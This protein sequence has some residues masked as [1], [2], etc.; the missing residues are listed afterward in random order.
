MKLEKHIL[1]IVVLLTSAIVTCAGTVGDKIHHYGLTFTSHTVN[2]DERTGMDLIP[3]KGLHFTSGFS[4]EFDLKLKEEDSTYGY[5]FRIISN[6]TTALDLVANLN[7]NKLNFIFVG[8]RGSTVANTEFRGIDLINGNRWIKVKVQLNQNE[9]C[10]TLD[11]VSRVIPYSFK[12]FKNIKIYFG[13]NKHLHFY[14]TDVPP[15]TIRNI[16]LKDDEERIVRKWTLAKHSENRVYDETNAHK[17]VVTHG[18]WEIE[19]YTRWK[20]KAS[21]SVDAKKTQIASDVLNGRV[22]V[23]TGNILYIYYIQTRELQRIEC[24]NKVPFVSG[25]SQMIYDSQKDRLISYSIVYPDFE[26]FDFTTREWSSDRID[27]G[28]APIQH[29]N[30]FIDPETNQ[31]IVFGGYGNHIYHSEVATHSLDG[32]SWQIDTLS[33]DIIPRYLSAVGFLGDGKFLVTGGYGSI[34]GKQ[35]E[36]PQNLYDLCE[37]DYINRTGRKLVDLPV[38]KEPRVLGNSMVIDKESNKIYTLV[39]NNEKFN[40]VIRLLSIDLNSKKQEILGDSIPFQFI[41]TESF[42]DLFLFEKTSDLYAVV[43]Q[44]SLSGT[45]RLELYSLA[46]PS[47][48]AADV[49]QTIDSKFSC[50]T[51]WEIIGGLIIV[52]LAGLYLFRRRKRKISEENITQVASVE[53]TKKT[54]IRANPTSTIR[55][56]GG[57]QVFSKTGEDITGNFTSVTR[58]LFIY[59][60]L[61]SAKKGKGVTSQKLDETFWYGMDKENASNNRNVNIRKLRLLLEK[62]ENITIINE[63][64]YWYLKI[65]KD[66][67]FDFKIVM[68]ILDN[69]KQKRIADKEEL[70]QVLNLT[71]TGVLL[72]NTTTDWADIYKAD[73]S[74]LLIDILLNATE[75]AEFKKDFKLLLKISDV[76]LMYD[77]INEEAVRIKCRVLYQ[78]GQKGLSKQSFDRFYASYLSLLNSEPNVKYDDLIKNG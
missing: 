56:F 53:E 23:A 72:P 76:I 28:L 71:S 78:R 46:Y 3:N 70:E 29:H 62:I 59:F 44:G 30:R 26:F 15:M 8:P 51:L 17:A 22:F 27:Q 12:N 42:S 77:T 65:E 37:V 60:L 64:S 10:C 58:P 21:F 24:N 57:F 55:F 2:Q 7:L 14:T 73:F 68:D 6:D 49:I 31:L 63:N 66:V 35:E 36:S 16:V 38:E 52:I 54:V 20:K 13:V 43:L 1:T 47:L 33:P 25:G 41:D 18:E 67:F 75:D 34:S 69:V 5:V 50:R 19:Q 45:S 39:F 11:T 48:N 9:I 74:N 4:I 40:S 32:G 61:N